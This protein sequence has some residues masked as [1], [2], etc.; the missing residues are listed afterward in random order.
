MRLYVGVFGPKQFAD[1]VAR[2]VFDHVD[3]LAAAYML[4]GALDAMRAYA[5]R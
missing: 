1:A 5:D 4:Q 3:K 2:E